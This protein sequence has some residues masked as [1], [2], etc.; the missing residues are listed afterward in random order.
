MKWARVITNDNL[1]KYITLGEDE[2]YYELEG[3]PFTK[4][5][6]TNKKIY[7]QKW[8]PPIDA[9]AVLCIGLNYRG[10]AKETNKPIPEYP[11]V[12][13]KNPS[14]LTGHLEPIILPRVCR[15]EVD[16]E[17]EL[18]IIIGKDA[19]DV[20]PDEAC[21]YIAG[22]TIGNDV[23]ARRWQMELGGGQWVRGKSFD[24]FAPLGPFVLPIEDWDKN[25]SFEITTKVNNQVMQSGN[26]SDMI[27]NVFQLVSF[28]SQDTTLKQGTLIFTGTPAG[29]GWARSPKVTLSK[30][31]IVEIEIKRIGI[32]RNEVK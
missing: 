18:V 24:T 1:R 7:P 8:L 14:A 11:V 26:S 5:N 13:M 21:Q 10:H 17:G 25:T 32:L 23:S 28:L 31:D 12:F 27:F 29:V 4:F 3:N 15:D 30:G 19:L 16:Y 6:I 2:N 20:E 9:P 22:F